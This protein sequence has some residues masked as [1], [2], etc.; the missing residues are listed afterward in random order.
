MTLDA[1]FVKLFM[2]TTSYVADVPGYEQL[3]LNFM[4]RSAC[5]IV[6]VRPICSAPAAKSFSNI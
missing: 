5:H 2:H 1:C 3:R 6:K 4:Q